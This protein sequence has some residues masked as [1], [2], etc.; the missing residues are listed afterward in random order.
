MGQGGATG[1][2]GGSATPGA[3]TGQ[4]SRPSGQPS[5]STTADQSGTASGVGA[6]DAQMVRVQALD[7]GVTKAQL[8]E[9][10]QLL[11]QGG[12]VDEVV[13]QLGQHLRSP[14]TIQLASNANAYSRA[15]AEQGMSTAQ[16]K[17]LSEDTGGFAQ[18]QTI[19]I[20]LYQNTSRPDLGNTLGHELVHVC[21]NEN[22]G[23]VPSWINEGLAVNTGMAVQRRIESAVA[24]G[25]YARRLA[26]SIIAAKTSG[27]WVPLAN[28]ETPLLTGAA[29][30]DLELQDWLAVA[31]LLQAKGHSP[32]PEYFAALRAGVSPDQAFARAFKETRQALDQRLQSLV[33]RA[34]AAKDPGLD[35]ALSI[36]KGYRGYL[37]ILPHGS[38]QWQG[39]R[40][41]SG[42]LRLTL[43]ADGHLKGAPQPVTTTQ[44]AAP[45]DTHTVYINLDPVQPFTYHG[46]SV[47]DSGFAIDYHDGLYGFVNAW[48]TTRDG[49]TVYVNRPEIFGVQVTRAVEHT[50]TNPLL[51]LLA[52]GSS[53]VG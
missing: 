41:S 22:V 28:T 32:L 52:A 46:K 10:T 50:A 8:T 16:A 14:V 42:E 25:G 20:P 47:R 13:A 45:A 19:V 31:D 1:P 5:G 9:V 3:A 43:T 30:Y 7:K 39:L 12:V 35:L 33:A 40:V 11:R 18:G 23:Q 48:I 44:D 38:Q 49:H 4:G 27:K 36:P 51:P 21:L 29:P 17:Q 26:E 37:R 6:R 15:L 2:Q 53:V 24:Y 34:A